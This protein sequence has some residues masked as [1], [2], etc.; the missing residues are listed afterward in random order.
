LA[1]AVTSGCDPK[2]P[3]EPI[4]RLVFDLAQAATAQDTEGFGAHLAAGFTGEGGLSRADALG[5]LRRYFVLY[6]SIEVGTAGL[7]VE[8]SGPS[9]VARFRASFAGKPRSPQAL[10]G[11]LPETA[12]FQ[13]ELTLVDEA[14]GL[15]VARAAWQRIESA[16]GDAFE[17]PQ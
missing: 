2:P 8:R 17:R 9:P 16:P 10:A 7:E 6:A 3:S 11:L 12:R 14:G 1:L 5:E 15:K 13:F 4:E